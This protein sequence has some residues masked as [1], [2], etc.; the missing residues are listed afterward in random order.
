MKQFNEN[1][2]DTWIKCID[3]YEV[4]KVKQDILNEFTNKWKMCMIKDMIKDTG[5]WFNKLYNIKLKCK[6]IKEK[7]HKL[8][9]EIKA[10][11]FDTPYEKYKPVCVSCNYNFSIFPTTASIKK[12]I[13]SRRPSLV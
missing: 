8:K 3:K 12:S 4:S 10:H 1:A 13:G 9:D 2:H 11:V 6:I 7:Y 5:V